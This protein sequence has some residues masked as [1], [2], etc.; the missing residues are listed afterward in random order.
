M[1]LRHQDQPGGEAAGSEDVMTKDQLVQPLHPMFERILEA[2]G[3][4]PKVQT[5]RLCAICG[6]PSSPRD[7]STEGFQSTLR[8]LGISGEKAHPRC[9]SAAAE[10]QLPLAGVK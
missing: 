1:G 7:G 9:V 8:R 4:K 3:M 10:R 5:T 2:H 6:K